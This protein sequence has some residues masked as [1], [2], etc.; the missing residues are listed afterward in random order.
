MSKIVKV[1]DKTGGVFVV[2]VL[3]AIDFDTH[4]EVQKAIDPLLVSTTRVL[5]LDMKGVEYIS[6]VG[7]GT[8]LK[9]KIFMEGVGGKFIMIELRPQVETVF[10]IIK[11]LPS[12]QV[13]ANMKEVD[14]YFMKIQRDEIDRK[15]GTVG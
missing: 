8:V 14:H 9:A 6:S 4:K 3:A 7:I 1:E 10:E 13:F 11:A 12:M 2:T 15:K 5:I